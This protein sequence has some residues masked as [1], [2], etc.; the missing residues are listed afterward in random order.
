MKPV[1]SEKSVSVAMATYN[2]ARYLEEQLVSI[3]SQTHPP[4]SIIICDDCSTDRTVEILHDFSLRYPS[5]QYTVNAERLGVIGNFK[6]AVSLANGDY[7]ALSDQDDIWMPEKLEALVCEMNR[8]ENAD[9]PAIVFSD[10]SVIDSNGKPL[11]PSFWNELGHDGYRHCYQTL[12]FGNFLTGCTILMNRNMKP[13]FAA[14]PQN[15]LMHDA[16][17]GLIAYS[18]GK[19]A[20]I[21]QPLVYYRKHENNTAYLPGYQKKNFYQRVGRHIK[22]LFAG[23]DYL[24]D[25][26]GMVRD[27]FSQY[28]D[29]LTGEQKQQT[30]K[31]LQL[32]GR[33]YL[34]K[35]IVFWRLFKPF[36]L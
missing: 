11:N 15:V 31:F 8:I 14:M 21:R 17:L 26:L 5:V 28:G 24:E 27:F 36:R 2:G 10:L 12:L 25:Q 23:H 22:M 33:S 32:R 7:I 9:L 3:L 1:L 18:F 19:V 4:D 20:E 16:W 6:K 30:Q 34:N 35:M 29:E 13:Y